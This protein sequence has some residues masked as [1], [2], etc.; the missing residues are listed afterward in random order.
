METKKCKTREE[1]NEINQLR[2]QLE[3]IICTFRIYLMAELRRRGYD[4][5]ITYTETH[6]IYSAT[7]K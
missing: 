2:K 3:E 6:T 4:G 7:I 5:T 1:K